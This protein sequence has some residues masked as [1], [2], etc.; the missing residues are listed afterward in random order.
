MN[1][2]FKISFAVLFLLIVFTGCKTK[3]ISGSGPNPHDA[4]QQLKDGTLIVF[5]QSY[6]NQLKEI[7]N[8]GNSEEISESKRA[9]AVLKYN[10]VFQKRDDD[11]AYITSSFNDHYNFSDVKFSFDYE[12]REIKNGSTTITEVIDIRNTQELEIPDN[13]FYMKYNTRTVT[14]IGDEYSW[15]ILNKDFEAIPRPFPKVGRTRHFFN[16]L[17]AAFSSKRRLILDQIGYGLNYDLNKFYRNH[18][19]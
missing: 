18:E 1:R 4:I 8:L 9:K 12:L 10:E 16:V 11:I 17:T 2:I 5:L 19:R 14:G 15:T 6:K 7:K 13:A 3:Y